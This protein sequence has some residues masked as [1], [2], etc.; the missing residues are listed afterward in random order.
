M[1]GLPFPKL[2]IAGAL[3]EGRKFLRYY[4]NVLEVEGDEDTGSPKF[5]YAVSFIAPKSDQ[6]VVVGSGIYLKTAK[7]VRTWRDSLTV[8]LYQSTVSPLLTEHDLSG[9]MGRRGN[10]CDNTVV[11]YPDR[12]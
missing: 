8:R 11:R 4:Y 5:G 2:L 10:P 9:L 6:K 12:R 7:P 3:R 1:N